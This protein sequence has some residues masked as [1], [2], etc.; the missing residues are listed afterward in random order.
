MELE[1]AV[2]IAKKELANRFDFKGSKA[3]ITLEKNEIKVSSS[4]TETGES[5]DSIET[6][7]DSDPIAIGFNSQYLLDFL[8]VSSGGEV[9]LEFKDGQSAGQMRPDDAKDDFKYRYIVMPM[10]I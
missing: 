5:E 2:N 4:S 1:N 10:R 8:K 9:K 6:K 3:E 7:Y